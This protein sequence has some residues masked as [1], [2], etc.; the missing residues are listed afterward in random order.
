MS[1]SGNGVKPA[2]GDKPYGRR[3]KP[4]VTPKAG[5]TTTVPPSHPF[6][7]HARTLPRLPR[8]APSPRPTYQS[9]RSAC[10]LTVKV[11]PWPLLP[12]ATLRVLPA[13]AGA[14]SDGVHDAPALAQADFGI[15]IGAGTDV[16]IETADVVLMRS[17][18]FDVP[19]ALTI[20]HA[21]LRKMRQNLGWAI[22]YN[23]VALPIAPGVFE[24]ILGLILRPEIAALTMSGSSFIV[25][26]NALLLKRHRLPQPD[27][28]ISLL[29]LPRTA[30]VD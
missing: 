3:P 7:P 29:G 11:G 10:E 6:T 27:P 20:G 28:S 17:D 30:D 4:G 24:P 5:N 19:T 22:G 21:T 26:M 25:A 23:A 8:S 12:S 18:P 13:S 1:C 9:A 15:A 2:R 14:W 16:A